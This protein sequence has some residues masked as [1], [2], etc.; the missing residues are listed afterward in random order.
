MAPTENRPDDSTAGELASPE[1]V[2]NSSLVR[3]I[4]P[5]ADTSSPSGGKVASVPSTAGD[6]SVWLKCRVRQG[7]LGSSDSSTEG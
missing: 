6:G 3:G 7:R 5:K 4:S 2:N 1:L